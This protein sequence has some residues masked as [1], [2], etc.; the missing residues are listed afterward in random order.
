MEDIRKKGEEM[1]E[2]ARKEGRRII[3]L[4]GRPYHVDPE[5]TT[6][7][8]SSSPVSARRS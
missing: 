2:Q 5:T 1:I 8:T 6:A 7:L 3:V 4:V